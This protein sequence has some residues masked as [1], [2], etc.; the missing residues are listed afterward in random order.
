MKVTLTRADEDFN[1]VAENED[2]NTVSIDAAAAIGGHN[3][4]ARPMQ[5]L[6]MGMGGCSGIDVVLMLRK[7]KIELNDF[8]IEIEA[9]RVDDV[10]KIFKDI[11]VT[12]RLKGEGDESRIKRA[13]GLS[14]DKYC[15]VTKIL[16]KSAEV[17]YSVFFNEIKL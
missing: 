13:V 1:F 10:P 14:M 17:T 16:E 15:S 7:Q 9:S 8:Q 2:G 12:F 5:L 11:H 4:G 3:E 6:L